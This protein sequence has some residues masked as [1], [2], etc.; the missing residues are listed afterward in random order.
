MDHG[1]WNGYQVRKWVYLCI[2]VCR[3]WA[4]RVVIHP[5]RWMTGEV[6]GEKN[7]LLSL[8]TWRKHR[9]E[10]SLGSQIFCGTDG[11][12]IASATNIS[13][14]LQCNVATIVA[15]WNNIHVL[16]HSLCG[17][18]IPQLRW[19][20]CLGSDKAAIKASARAESSSWDS[21][22][23]GCFP[24]QTGSWQN[25]FPCSAKA[26]DTACLL[27]QQIVR[28][29]CIPR[30]YV[31]FLQVT[32]YS[33]QWGFPQHNCLLHQWGEFL[34][35]VCMQWTLI[36]QL[37]NIITRVTRDDMSLPC[38]ILCIRNKLQLFSIPKGRK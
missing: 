10:L 37:C 6:T 15:A 28:L 23:E 2:C 12:D 9:T 14:Q 27:Y 21:A 18:G 7:V 8:G 22:G 3:Q 29:L 1:R 24:A 36:T 13:Y 11:L 34:Y 32:N 4:C 33:S 25:T 5:F 20:L 26:K 30:G 35:R 17:A 38:H 31:Q 16:S 19:I